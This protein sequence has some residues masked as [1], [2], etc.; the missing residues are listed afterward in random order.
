MVVWL[1]SEAARGVQRRLALAPPASRRSPATAWGLAAA[2][3]GRTARRRIR[4]LPDMS[5]FNCNYT[6]R[7]R[8]LAWLSTPKL[9]AVRCEPLT[10]LNRTVGK[11][12]VTRVQRATMLK[13][14]YFLLGD[15]GRP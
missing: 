4:I 14:P 1:D 9:C 15:F 10:L 8:S 7:E 12:S 3:C 2:R 5:N 11:L 6:Y 13:G